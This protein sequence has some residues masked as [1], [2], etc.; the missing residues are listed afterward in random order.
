[1]SNCCCVLFYE[2]WQGITSENLQRLN[3]INGAAKPIDRHVAACV[4]R[5]DCAAAAAAAVAAVAG[6]N[7][8]GVYKDV[9]WS[10]FGLLFIV[11]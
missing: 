4:N 9:L 6:W 2:V 3:I 11:E 1:M 8:G 5:C 10:V 7:R